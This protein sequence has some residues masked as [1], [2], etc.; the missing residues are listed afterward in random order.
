MSSTDLFSLAG[1]SVL[2]TGATAGLGRRF[3]QT[4]GEAGARV[5]LVGRRAELLAEVAGGTPGCVAVPG[6]LG[7]VAAVPGLVA[8]AV[9]AVGDI[10]VVVNNA[11]FIAGGVRA[12][13]ES[14]DDITATLNVNL[15][16]PIRIVQELFPTW[17]DR[18][19][20]VIVNV[21]S[22][23]ARAGIARFPQA[24]Y[25]ASKGGMEAITREWAAQWARHG[26]RAN[27]LAPGFFESEMTGGVI[28]HEKIQ[29]WILRNT[30]IPRH[31]QP[32]D[33]D[34]ALLFL[35]SEA[36]SYVTGQTVVVDGG[37]TAH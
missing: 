36:S 25:A 5:A 21:T 17:R 30:L 14:V 35:A 12:E 8:R 33:F 3:A 28:H 22:I 4:L 29:D 20:G 19:A 34:G 6:D 15:V 2:L 23:A 9:D 13:D 32:A 16:S 24:V 31:G 10:D 18:G 1:R 27:C 11:A 37:W 26:I 7:D